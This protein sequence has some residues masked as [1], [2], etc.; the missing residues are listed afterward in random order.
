MNLNTIHVKAPPVRD[1]T[2]RST[3]GG[4]PDDAIP[5]GGEQG[6]RLIEGL[7]RGTNEE[8]APKQRLT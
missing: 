4:Y 5:H 2:R 6:R 3:Y 7:S 8:I 1:G